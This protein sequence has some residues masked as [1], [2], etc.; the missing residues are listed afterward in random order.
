M[1]AACVSENAVKAAITRHMTPIGA[2]WH[3]VA[4]ELARY[5]I[6]VVRAKL[7]KMIRRGVIDGCASC[8]N[9]RGD[10]TIKEPK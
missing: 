6:K 3:L 2:P 7:R 4:E 8:S 5:P 1:K 9:C 10:F